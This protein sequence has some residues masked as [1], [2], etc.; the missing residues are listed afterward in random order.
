MFYTCGCREPN[1][2]D[3][4]VGRRNGCREPFVGWGG[5]GWGVFNNTFQEPDYTFSLTCLP[6][7][8]GRAP[9]SPRIFFSFFVFS[10]F[11]PFFFFFS[12]SPV[13]KK[14]EKKRP[15]RGTGG[16]E[17]GIFSGFFLPFFLFHFFSL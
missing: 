3:L 12:P 4:F 10:F 17:R 14:K 1:V 15:G 2:D 7:R 6:S 13:A 5:V 16:D 11:P 9:R 8:G